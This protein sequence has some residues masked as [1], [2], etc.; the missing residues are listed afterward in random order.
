MSRSQ[1]QTAK[2]RAHHACGL[3]LI[4]VPLLVCAILIGYALSDVRRPK[5]AAADARERR[6]QS[7]SAAVEFWRSG[8]EADFAGNMR[9]P[10]VNISIPNPAGLDCTQAISVLSSELA[11]TSLT[12]A[13]DMGHSFKPA[14]YRHT[15]VELAR[16]TCT[17]ART[18][19]G[20]NETQLGF[21]T[22]RSWLTPVRFTVTVTG[23]PQ[24]RTADLPP[25]I[26]VPVVPGAECYQRW[27]FGMWTQ[28]NC[29]DWAEPFVQQPVSGCVALLKLDSV[30][31]AIR[32]ATGGPGS[33]L[34]LEGCMRGRSHSR[35]G[36]GPASFTQGGG[37]S[38]KQEGTVTYMPVSGYSAGARWDSAYYNYVPGNL[39]W[40]LS[41]R[42][43][44]FQLLER[45]IS[46]RSG[47]DPALVWERSADCAGDSDSTTAPACTF[48][49][50]PR[51]FDAFDLRLL[52]SS[53]ACGALAAACL[54]TALALRY[55]HKLQA[56][57]LVP[58]STG[59]ELAAGVGPH[60][61][62]QETQGQVQPPCPVQHP[63]LP[64]TTMR[65]LIQSG[66]RT[67]MKYLIHSFTR[68]G[69]GCQPKEGD[70]SSSGALMDVDGAHATQ[71]RF[72]CVNV[73]D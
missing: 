16:G 41:P 60:E 66:M 15:A 33:G 8:G 11:Y 4:G 18:R 56:L 69:V 29:P 32:N 25:Y 7:I 35:V 43:A 2:R 52:H 64:A 38:P 55:A 20:L 31:L 70:R 10:T 44:P 72:V 47:S 34:R 36:T 65:I 71:L 54:L 67:R 37:G 51:A 59:S 21:Y 53:V 42:L 45:G 50:S 14:A 24:A 12:S 9:A 73:S 23:V 13:P 28:C 27:F 22:D 26:Y 39:G 30:C 58:V 5:D 17:D 40:L 62:R 57:P 1:V 46:I 3:A 61:E 49:P 19:A 6:A 63:A 48:A 68:E